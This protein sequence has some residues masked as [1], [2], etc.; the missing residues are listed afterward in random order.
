MWLHFT[1]KK[2]YLQNNESYSVFIFKRSSE[3]GDGEKRGG[4]LLSGSDL[5]FGADMS[6]CW[7]QI[8]TECS[9][10]RRGNVSAAAE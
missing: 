8:Q 7:T 10:S 9:I 3:N 2:L 4:D 5:G 6:G 1:F